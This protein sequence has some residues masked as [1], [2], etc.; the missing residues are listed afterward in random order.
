M[1]PLNLMMNS[2]TLDISREA[3]TTTGYN[4][5]S[6]RRSLNKPQRFEFDETC[7]PIATQRDPI[8]EEANESEAIDLDTIEKQPRWRK[9][10]VRFSISSNL[11]YN[12]NETKPSSSQVQ[13][14]EALM[15]SMS[16]Y[17]KLYSNANISM[18]TEKNN[19]IRGSLV[20]DIEGR[21]DEVNAKSLNASIDLEPENSKEYYSRNQKK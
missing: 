17:H 15:A 21:N 14:Q 20:F 19:L 8:D 7:P 10:S 5:S 3:T 2:Q 18:M 16:N 6:Q 1:M 12:K 11:G 4:L 9:G 13:N